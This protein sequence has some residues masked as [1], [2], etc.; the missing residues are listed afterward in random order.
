MKWWEIR[1][2]KYFVLGHV[3]SEKHYGDL[4]ELNLLFEIMLFNQ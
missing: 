4:L 3:T 1:K 2:I